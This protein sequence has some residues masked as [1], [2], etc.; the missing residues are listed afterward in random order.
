MTAKA[1]FLRGGYVESLHRM[2]GVAVAKNGEAFWQVGEAD[3]RTFWRSGAKPFQVLPFLAA[4]GMARFGLTDSELALMCA[5]HSGDGFHTDGV[6]GM[7]QKLGL[8]VDALECGTAEPL[9]P[10]IAREMFRK[11]TPFSPLHNDCSGKHCG[12]LG[13]AILKGYKLSGYSGADHPVQVSVRAAVAK[14]AGTGPESMEAGLDGCGVPTFRLPL[15][16]MARAYARLAL[17]SEDFWGGEAANVARVRDAMRGYPENVGGLR[18]FETVLMQVTKG[19]LLAKLGAEASFCIAHCEE[20]AG[21]VFKVEDGGMRAL[22]H[23]GIQVLDKL[24][25]ISAADKQALLQEFSPLIRNDHGQVVGSV[26]I[27]GI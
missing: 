22:P 11:G 23:F 12:M 24:G 7:L 17:P 20:G 13:L 27:T 26:D 9:D 2:H 3:Y 19:R 5:S 4:G 16:N 15:V 1:I 6:T 18:R 14:A 21:L 25:W 8:G 10:K